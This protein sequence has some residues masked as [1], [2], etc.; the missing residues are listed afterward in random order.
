MMTKP[1]LALFLALIPWTFAGGGSGCSSDPT[2]TVPLR[3]EGNAYHWLWRPGHPDVEVFT[4]VVDCEWNGLDDFGPGDTDS[5]DPQNEH[6]FWDYR[7]IDGR[8]HS[9]NSVWTHDLTEE[10]QAWAWSTP[11]LRFDVAQGTTYH[12]AVQ[13]TTSWCATDRHQFEVTCPGM[14]PITYYSH[15]GGPLPTWVAPEDGVCGIDVRNAAIR[16]GVGPEVLR[17]ECWARDVFRVYR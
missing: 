2:V 1:T 15:V 6:A 10:S 4:Q 3:C 11:L 17:E 9:T 14:E 12:V 7:V 5:L 8:W 13:T 16:A